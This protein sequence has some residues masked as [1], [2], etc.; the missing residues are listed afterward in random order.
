MNSYLVGASLLIALVALVHTVLGELLIFRRLRLV[1]IV[2]TNGGDILKERHVRILWGTWHA[3]SVLAWGLSL[4][5]WQLAGQPDPE[6]VYPGTLI[7]IS[8]SVL[9]SAMLVF[10]GTRARHPGWIGLLAVAVLI[11]L[12]LPA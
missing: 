1:G 10:I 7:T 3:V 6:A 2:P 8:I 9:A 4:I 5:L 12:G 11:W